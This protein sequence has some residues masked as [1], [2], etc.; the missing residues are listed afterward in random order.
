MKNFSQLTGQQQFPLPTHWHAGKWWG[1][2]STNEF[3]YK[4]AIEPCH[5][6]DNSQMYYFTKFPNFQK[7][8][9][10]TNN[11]YRKFD[12]TIPK[13]IVYSGKIDVTYE[14]NR[15]SGRRH[16]LPLRPDLKWKWK[17]HEPGICFIRETRSMKIQRHSDA[18]IIISGELSQWGGDH[19][20]FW[21]V[22][23]CLFSQTL[24]PVT[25]PF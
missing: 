7:A 16:H 12:L 3:T 9:Q 21:W 15:Q 20:H 10:A 1:T 25:S 17:P 4:S 24:N 6:T 2:I 19:Q 8:F 14:S 13:K 11:F 22:V 23:T 5:N 18:K